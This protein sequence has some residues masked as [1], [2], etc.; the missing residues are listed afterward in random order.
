MAVP[1]LLK[2]YREKVVPEM[3][4]KHKYTS[5]MQVPRLSKIVINMGIGE[6]SQDIKILD[7]AMEELAA[8]TGQKP[9]I[10]R[11]KKAIANFKIKQGNPIGCKVTLRRAMMYEFLDRFVNVAVPRI[12]DFQG[13]SPKAFDQ[14]GNYNL[15]ITEQ[16][17]FPEVDVDRIGSAQGMDIAIVTTAK[18]ASEALELLKYFGMPF[19]AEGN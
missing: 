19:K 7:K 8:I 6:A 13:L 9:V 16:G 15:G 11:A 10:C 4:A 14:R 17:I 1:R 18:T 5:P 3:M 2:F 12:R